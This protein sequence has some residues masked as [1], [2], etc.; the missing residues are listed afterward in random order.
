MVVKKFEHV[1]SF[2]RPEE[3]LA[4]RAQFEAGE[5]SAADLQAVEDKAIIELVDKQV[6]AGL[7]RVTDGEFRRSD[8]HLDFFWGFEGIAHEHFG[9][10]LRFDGEETRDDTAVLTG[11]IAFNKETHPFIRHYRFL[12]ALADERGVEAKLSIPAPS[13]LLVELVRGK[14]AQTTFSLY[15]SPQDLFEDI[16]VAYQAAIQAFYNLGLRTL[17]MDDCT[18]TALVD[19]DFWATVAAA[20]VDKETVIQNHLYINNGAIAKKPA[21]LTVNTHV[22]RGNYHSTYATKGPYDKVADALFNKE[23][24]QTYF[25]EYDD[26]RSGGFEPLAK[27]P[28]DKAVVLGLITT[29]TGEL[30]DKETLLKRIEEAR[31]YADLDQLWISTQCGFASTQ[32]GNILTQ[33]DQWQKLA[34]VKEVIDEVWR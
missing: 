4:A 18:W 2:L 20:G 32:E 19:D 15:S 22:C 3:V 8:W 6:Q 7:E 25:L 10:G 9:E 16:I 12:K 5:I 21:D 34:L 17:Q 26:E 13:Q 31:Q 28:A 29:K 1:G 23:N 30:E 24:A 14:N 27:L 33:E 11:R